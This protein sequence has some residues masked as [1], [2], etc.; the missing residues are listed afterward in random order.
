MFH[1][2][3]KEVVSFAMKGSLL[4]PHPVESPEV[5]VETAVADLN[6]AFRLYELPVS[7]PA[8]AQRLGLLYLPDAVSSEQGKLTEYGSSQSSYS[9]V[10]MVMKER[11]RIAVAFRLGKS[12]ADLA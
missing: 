9:T 8:D 12:N 5:Y 2:L 1:E 3:A 7:R 6:E 10:A 4:Q 11:I